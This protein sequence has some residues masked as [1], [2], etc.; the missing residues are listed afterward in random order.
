MVRRAERAR[1]D[2]GLLHEQTADAVNLG[3]FDGL[4]HRHGRQDGRHTLA[5]HRFARARWTDEQQAVAACGGDFDRAL[6]V[7]LAAHVRKI[8][9]V[10]LM[11]REKGG[12]VFLHRFQ[13]QLSREEGI[14]LAQILHAIDFDAFD[15]RGLTDIR[16]GHHDFLAPTT[17]R[18][19]RDGQHTAHGTDRAIQC[20]FADETEVDRICQLLVQ[21][22][23]HHRERNRQ[24]KARPLFLHVCRGQI[25][26]HMPAR[27]AQTAIGDGGFHPIPCLPHRG[28]RQPNNHRDVLAPA[29]GTHF[30]VEIKRLHAIDSGGEHFGE[31]RHWCTVAGHAP[32]VKTE[33]ETLTACRAS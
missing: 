5:H 18:F 13:L 14:A 29:R 19:Q 11:R 21:G 22:T 16:R 33:V 9:V 15:H 17:T 3:G 12:E 6:H 10:V 28:I 23:R 20:E 2:E 26:G 25:H 32:R 30:N 27:P 31:G 7:V 24:I 8:G 1:G 4:L